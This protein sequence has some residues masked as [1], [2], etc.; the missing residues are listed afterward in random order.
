MSRQHKTRREFLK[1]SAATAAAVSVPYFF[2]S[3]RS[4]AYAFRSANERPV[5]ARRRTLE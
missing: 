2:T 1:T 4:R 5:P 3:E